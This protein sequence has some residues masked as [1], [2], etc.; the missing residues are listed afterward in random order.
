MTTVA[1]EGSGSSVATQAFVAPPPPTPAPAI[2]ARATDPA[3]GAV[4][5]GQLAAWVADAARQLPE[6]ASAAFAEIEAGLSV[7][8][9]SRF[10][11]DVAAQAR[12]D[13]PPVISAFGIAQGPGIAGSR[14]LR[15][16]PI[17]EV[18]W[19][20]TTSPVTNLGGFSGPLQ[21][22]LDRSGIN[23]DFDVAPKPAGALNDSSPSMRTRNGAAARDVIADEFASRGQLVG[24]EQ[25]RTTSLGGRNVD[26]VADV[27][28]ARPELNKHIE[29]ESKLGTASAG[30]GTRL[31]VAKDVER[32]TA[33]V[34]VR[35]L[36]LRFEN[37]GK[38]AR[39][40]GIALDAVQVGQA[41]RADGNSIGVNTQRAAGSLA[42]GAAGAW[43]GAQAG[44]ALGSAAGPVGTVVGGV[45]GAIV[46]GI[47]GSGIGAKAVDWV[48]SW[49]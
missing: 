42:G 19:R 16:N 48:R 2:I 34:D 36:G 8:D 21:A 26:I 37:I 31:Q 24:I 9:A 4:D 40:I 28:G 7:G 3:T 32:L 17:L 33:N 43:G 45:G 47:I 46:G 6:A 49:F 22:L 15:D 10:N 1:I 38:V 18:Q 13:Q 12:G 25:P 41:Y 23:S 44:A 11:A 5:T 27:P 20:S 30:V 35:G 29:V 39:P 14:I